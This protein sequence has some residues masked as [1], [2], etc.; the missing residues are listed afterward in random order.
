MRSFSSTET[1]KNHTNQ[2]T[3]HGCATKILGF[4]V[5]FPIFFLLRSWPFTPSPLQ[6]GAE[7]RAALA[8]ESLKN[9]HPGFLLRVGGF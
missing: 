9:E 3:S 7:Y 2:K 4:T 6:C 5:V 1:K 8:E